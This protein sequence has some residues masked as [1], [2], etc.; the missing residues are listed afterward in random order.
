MFSTVI[1]GF[2]LWLDILLYNSLYL[3]LQCTHVGHIAGQNGGIRLHVTVKKSS[4]NVMSAVGG[5]KLMLEPHKT[6]FYYHCYEHTH[7]SVLLHGDCLQFPLL[8]CYRRKRELLLT[9]TVYIQSAATGFPHFGTQSV[10]LQAQHWES[11]KISVC[12]VAYRGTCI[13]ANPT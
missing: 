12:M 13:S 5:L 3:S 10:Y 11:C 8:L 9:I 7:M 2:V 1:W 6:Q 4:N